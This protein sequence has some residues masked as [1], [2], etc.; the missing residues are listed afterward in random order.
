VLPVPG[1]G[2]EVQHRMAA[3]LL[4]IAAISRRQ[5]KPLSVRLLP[6]CDSLPGDKTRFDFNPYIINGTVMDF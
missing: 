1:S 6:V 2:E 3:L 4:D 5:K